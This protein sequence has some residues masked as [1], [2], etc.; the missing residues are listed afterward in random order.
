META[1]VTT[2]AAAGGSNFFLNMLGGLWAV[3]YTHLD[4]YKRQMP[5][6]L[7]VLN[8]WPRRKRSFIWNAATATGR[9]L[10][11]AWLPMSPPTPLSPR[12]CCRHHLP[13]T[14]RSNRPPAARH[15]VNLSLI[16][17]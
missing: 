2:T 8:R 10:A 7:P 16:H 12:I 14:G 13:P 6:R 17:I 3:S 9:R 1:T 4:V 5:A 11:T 15:G